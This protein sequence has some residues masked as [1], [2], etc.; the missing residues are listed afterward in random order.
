METS[1]VGVW[2]LLDCQLVCNKPSSTTLDNLG[3]L[4]WS[5]GLFQQVPVPK[6]GGKLLLLHRY[7]PYGRSQT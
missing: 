4:L 7:E 3:Y 6:T 2:V 5:S 1:L